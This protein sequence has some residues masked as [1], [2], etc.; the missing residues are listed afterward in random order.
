MSKRFATLLLGIGLIVHRRAVL[1][2]A[3][4]G[5]RASVVDAALARRPDPGGADPRR[6]LI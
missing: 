6:G 4:A 2:R 5:F 3:G 1:R